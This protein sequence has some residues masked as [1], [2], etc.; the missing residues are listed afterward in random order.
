MLAVLATGAL[1]TPG[2]AAAHE[3][4]AVDGYDILFGGA[5]EPVI[6]GERMWLEV[7]ITDSETEDPVT[8][9]ED[10]RSVAV[11]RPF[12]NDTFDFEVESR[13]GQP[14]VVRGG[15]RFHGTGDLHGLP[16]RVDPWDCVRDSFQKRVHNASNSGTLNQ[17][18][19]PSRG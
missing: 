17:P 2:P 13:F 3:T 7:R 6:T 11:Q 16:L 19:P 15:S 9:L 18:R 10:D 4:A 5:D 14:G 1:K 12:G 8:D